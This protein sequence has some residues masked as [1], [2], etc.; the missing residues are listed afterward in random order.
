MATN[1]YMGIWYYFSPASVT[2]VANRERP[3]NDSS[4]TVSI[5]SSGNI[6]L[7][8]GNKEI[9]W[10]SDVTLS[11]PSHTTARLLNSGNLVLR[12]TSIGR[13]LWRSHR[14]PVDSFLPKMRVS[15][16]PRTN[17]TVALNSWRS[18]QDPGHGNFTSGIHA[19]GIPQIYI[20][21]KGI[22]RWR[23]GPWNGQILTG[24]TDMYSVYVSGFSVGTEVDGTVY[25]TRSFQQK[26]LYRD[27]LDA[28]GSCGGF[29][30]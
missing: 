16:N 29:L 5:S 27:F 13:I 17:E 30:G 20:W 24:V 12:D 6:V 2:W 19:L 21:D 23:S 11:L 8:N 1:R 9:I 28:D 14:H 4:G 7:M 10:S 15:H 26:F 25:F 3:L 22:P 18:L